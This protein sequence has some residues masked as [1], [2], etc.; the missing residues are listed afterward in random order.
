M[1]T[2]LGM[3]DITLNLALFQSS[4]VCPESFKIIKKKELGNF[5][6]AMTSIVLPKLCEQI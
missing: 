5:N 6:S 4:V 3:C 1:K 2:C